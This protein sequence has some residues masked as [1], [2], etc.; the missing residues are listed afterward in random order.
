MIKALRKFDGK[1]YLFLYLILLF[2]SDFYNYQTFHLFRQSLAFSVAFYG[3][4]FRKHE[5]RLLLIVCASLLHYSLI[6]F[7]LHEIILLVF[8]R[9][10]FVVT[11]IVTLVMWLVLRKITSSMIPEQYLVYREGYRFLS[12]LFLLLTTLVVSRFFS[13]AGEDVYRTTVLLLLATCVFTDMFQ[14]S[15]RLFSIV[16]PLYTV[17]LS[18][19]LINKKWSVVYISVVVVFGAL[20]YRVLYPDGMLYLTSFKSL[21]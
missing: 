19:L 1:Y 14:I 21:L 7:L 20:L 15:A 17:C 11:I 2:S 10:H 5:N 13:L 18:G 8:R 12:V 9:R 6:L 16:I 4:M 3:L